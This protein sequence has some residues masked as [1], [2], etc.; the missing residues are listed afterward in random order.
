M[1]TNKYPVNYYTTIKMPKFDELPTLGLYS[2]Q[3][4]TY[5]NTVLE[6]LIIDTN[7]PIITTAMV[8]NYVKSGLIK[9][10]NKKRYD[11]THIAYLIMICIFKQLYSIGK[12]HKMIKMQQNAITVE[13]TYNYFCTE[14][15]KAIICAFNFETYVVNDS[16]DKLLPERALLRGTV[17][18]FAQKFLVEKYV[19]SI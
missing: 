7:V 18:A 12:I 15:E 14:L 8:N 4:L 9:P 1:T 3:L 17:L 13:K 5:L 19:D 16:Y 2:D 10:T 11:N 6:P